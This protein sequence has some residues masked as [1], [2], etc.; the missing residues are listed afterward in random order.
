MKN[1]QQQ[2]TSS[3]K[4]KEFSNLL[5]ALIITTAAIHKCS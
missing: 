5:T 4:L 1:W 2:P 3:C